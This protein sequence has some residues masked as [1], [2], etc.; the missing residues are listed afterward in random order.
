M[1]MNNNKISGRPVPLMLHLGESKVVNNMV[2][3][4]VTIILSH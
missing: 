4:K 1:S 2:A 3:M